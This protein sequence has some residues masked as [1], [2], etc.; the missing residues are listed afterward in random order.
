MAFNKKAIKCNICGLPGIVKYRATSLIDET[1][2]EG[3]VEMRTHQVKC[4]GHI[5]IHP[6]KWNKHPQY[7]K[8]LKHAV[9]QRGASNETS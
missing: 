5:G 8:F 2:P 9:R 3:K 7:D 6:S 1:V 4:L